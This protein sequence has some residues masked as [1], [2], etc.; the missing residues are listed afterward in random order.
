MATPLAQMAHVRV[1]IGKKSGGF[2]NAGMA[3]FEA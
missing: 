1:S 3:P 2:N